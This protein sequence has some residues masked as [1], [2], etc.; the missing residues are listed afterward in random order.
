MA[1][2]RC[3][4]VDDSPR[5]L[6]AVRAMLERE[7]VAIVGVATTTA[8]ALDLAEALQPDVILIDVGLGAESGFELARAIGEQAESLPSRVVLISTHA[9]EDFADLIET[10]PV[11]GFLSKSE[12]SG[13]A[14]RDLLGESGDHRRERQSR[15]GT[16]GT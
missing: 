1:R 7:G 9:H 13:R 5:F 2:L 12:L 14:L 15:N 11:A 4:V 8:D 6:E 3:L 16:R 10:S